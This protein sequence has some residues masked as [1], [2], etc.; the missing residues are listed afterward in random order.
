MRTFNFSIKV[1]CTGDGQANLDRVEE[2]IAMTM[3]ELVMDD[4]FIAELDEKEAVAIET[5]LVK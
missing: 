1:I 5:N 2:M 4:T 3:Q